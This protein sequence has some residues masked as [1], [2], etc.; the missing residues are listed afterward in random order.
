MDKIIGFLTAILP[1]I[2]IGLYLVV[3]YT[4]QKARK[5][6]VKIPG[7]LKMIGWGP[8]IGFLLVAAM[9][10]SEGKTSS[11]ITCWTASDIKCY[12]IN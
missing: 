7:K 6:G 11:A 10:F 12:N 5:A 9:E 4:Q 1:W 2:V 8:M 3:V